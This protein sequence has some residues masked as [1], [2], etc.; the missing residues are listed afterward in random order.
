MKDNCFTIYDTL[1]NL[2]GNDSVMYRLIHINRSHCVLYFREPLIL[3]T[4]SRYLCGTLDVFIQLL[5]FQ[6][7]ILDAS[8]SVM[9]V[10]PPE[11]P[12]I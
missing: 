11:F 8:K 12:T 4:I 2:A 10:P 9:S 5:M 1:L 3:P 6:L 7:L